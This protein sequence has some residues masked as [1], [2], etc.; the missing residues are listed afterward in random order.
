[1]LAA[2]L[3]RHRCNGAL[4][5]LQQRLLHALTRH[6]AGNRRVI[7]LPR[8]LVDF[9]DIDDAGLG[10]LDVV[11]ALLQQLLNDVL[12]IFTDVAGLG[13]RR[14]IRDGE[15]ARSAGGPAFRPAASCHSPSGR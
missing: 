14:G 4:N 3:R 8:N 11:V 7:R 2:T 15:R 6:V 5:Q 10:L 9:I 1:M 12:D 13:E